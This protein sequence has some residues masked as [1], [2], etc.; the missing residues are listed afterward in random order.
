MKK[1]FLTVVLGLIFLAAPAFSA[2]GLDDLDYNFIDNAFQNPN[3]TTNKQ[4]E[5]VMDKFEN[6]EPKG[7]FYNLKKFFN[8]DNPEYDSELKKR[9]EEPNNQPLRI[10][11]APE[12]KPTVTIGGDFSDSRGKKLEAGH[13]Q[14]DFKKGYDENPDYYTIIL[15]QGNT[16]AADI[17]AIPYED[18]WETPA[19]V[20]SRIENVQDGLIRLIYA[21]LDITI[22]G[23]IRLDN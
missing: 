12:S 13:Y 5:E 9:Y 6:R 17:K 21:N 7:F 1:N 8:R 10:K 14:V 15:M 3:P 23:Y 4:F 2:D 19:V 16:K 22:Q 20:Y 18:D 11:E